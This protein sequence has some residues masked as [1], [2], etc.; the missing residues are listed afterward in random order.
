MDPQ[1]AFEILEIDKNASIKEIKQKYRDL[2][3]IWHPDRH[4]D[5]ARLHKLSEEKM[6]ELNAAYGYICNY[7]ALQKEVEQNYTESNEDDLSIIRCK[8]CGTKNRVGAYSSN[9]ILKCGK[10]G[11]IIF[12][13]E[14]TEQEDSWHERTL[15][16]DDDCVGTIGSDGRCNYCGKSFEEGKKESDYKDK[17][18][19]EALKRQSEKAKKRGWLKKAY[20]V[21][22]GIALTV[23]F[24]VIY[25]QNINIV[26]DSK[27]S[28]ST[29]PIAQPKKPKP[30]SVKPKTQQ[31]IKLKPSKV[32]LDE[33]PN[34]ES[35][36]TKEYF[37]GLNLDKH[38]VKML[39][40]NLS[41][42]G[43][44][45]GNADGILG[46]KTIK[47]VRQFSEDFYIVP[48]DNFFHDL[49]KST[50]KHS[51]ISKDHPDW[52]EIF[53]TND[54]E[55]WVN[56]QPPHFKRI[57]AN[58]DTENPKVLNTLLNFYKF[59]IH[60]PPALDLPQSG[61]VRKAFSEGLAPLQIKT[62]HQDQ[63]HYIKLVNIAN[64]REILDLFI[65][66]GETVTVDVPLGKF[67]IKSAIGETWYG[68]RYLFG[69]NASY[70]KVDKMFHFRIEGGRYAGYTLELFLQRHG[71][72]KES[73]ISAFDF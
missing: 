61:I 40:R 4:P 2:A 13:F 71:N 68:M 55:K 12:G 42:I 56:K 63:N 37:G 18:R 31:E 46:D 17:T 39:Q 1:R 24:L 19:N 34:Y 27:P 5:N 43:Y 22:F 16:G 45:V 65:R 20:Y 38:Q 10:C 60:K 33:I 9:Y 6:K 69:P 15:C 66:K 58:K 8:N 25:S 11:T 59:A 57:I 72:L 23:F 48:K 32:I 14:Q 62:R 50:H 47:A 35:Y 52:C 7:L 64:N 54:L 41:I 73:K 29:T 49:L 67:Q 36:F 28:E 30:V 44:N 51:L 70:S 53:K 26:S 3:S 21:S